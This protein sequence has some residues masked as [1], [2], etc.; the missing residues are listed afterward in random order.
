MSAST[1]VAGTEYQ[2]ISH[3]MNSRYRLLSSNGFSRRRSSSILRC[4]ATR[5]TMSGVDRSDMLGSP[6]EGDGPDGCGTPSVSTGGAAAGAGCSGSSQPFEA[7]GGVVELGVGLD[8]AGE[9]GACPDRVAGL[10]GQGA[11]GVGEA[12]VVVG[13]LGRPA[14]VAAD[15][16]HPGRRLAEV[17]VGRG[18]DQ[19]QL[20]CGVG[21]PAGAVG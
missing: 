17:A 6:G 12:Q 8:H 2:G 3:S 10:L 20:G 15:Q 4:Q 5:S 7:L 14:G 19:E 21:V 18:G 1:E 9:G 11:L 13:E 16:G